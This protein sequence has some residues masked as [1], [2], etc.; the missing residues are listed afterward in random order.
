MIRK[1]L[2]V[3][4]SFVGIVM[5]YAAAVASNDCACQECDGCPYVYINGIG[6]TAC[7]WCRDEGLCTTLQCDFDNMCCTYNGAA[8]TC[9][10]MVYGSCEWPYYRV[11]GP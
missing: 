10:P 7:C 8:L 6:N 9:G 1:P 4:V 5:N 3:L 2:L 11:G